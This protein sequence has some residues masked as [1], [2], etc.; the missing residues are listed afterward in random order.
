M[1]VIYLR[2]TVMDLLNTW[3]SRDVDI[4][5]RVRYT[6]ALAFKHNTGFHG[7]RQLHRTV[8]DGWRNCKKHPDIAL[9]RACVMSSTYSAQLLIL[10]LAYLSAFEY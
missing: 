6:E 4:H 8:L 1:H 3:L 10:T 5:L 2:D 9:V 7:D